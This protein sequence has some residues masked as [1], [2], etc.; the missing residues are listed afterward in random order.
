MMKVEEAIN[1]IKEIKQLSKPFSGIIFLP[2]QGPVKVDFPADD[3]YQFLTKVFEEGGFQRGLPLKGQ[4]KASDVLNYIYEMSKLQSKQAIDAYYMNRYYEYIKEADK[5]ILKGLGY[6]A[7]YTLFETIPRAFSN[8]TLGISELISY[9]LKTVGVDEFSDIYNYAMARKAELKMLNN[10]GEQFMSDYLTHKGFGGAVAA[11]NDLASFMYGFGA[12]AGSLRKLG[13]VLATKMPEKFWGKVGRFL[14]T[15]EVA[16]APLWKKA[17]SESLTFT[18]FDQI[19]GLFSPYRYSISDIFKDL[20]IGGKPSGEQIFE[21]T[22]GFFTSLLWGAVP[23][24]SRAIDSGLLAIANKFPKSFIVATGARILRNPVS[25]AILYELKNTPAFLVAEV[26]SQGISQATAEILKTLG[27]SIGPIN[28][29]LWEGIYGVGLMQLFNMGMAGVL[30]HRLA[31][32]KKEILNELARLEEE[33]QKTIQKPAEVIDQIT[34]P[35]SKPAEETKVDLLKTEQDL[36]LQ[37]VDNLQKAREVVFAQ[38]LK[39]NA[40]LDIAQKYGLLE[41]VGIEPSKLDLPTAIFIAHKDLLRSLASIYQTLG[42]IYQKKP[43]LLKDKKIG[44]DLMEGL[45]RALNF[46]ASD[47]ERITGG[48]YRVLFEFGELKNGFKPI[49][50]IFVGKYKEGKVENAWLESF[51]GFNN[52]IKEIDGNY[53]AVLEDIKK[54]TDD[55]FKNY[56]KAGK[57]ILDLVYEQNVSNLYKSFMDVFFNPFQVFFTR[58]DLTVYKNKERFL[59]LFEK[60]RDKIKPEDLIIKF[61][62]LVRKYNKILLFSHFTEGLPTYWEVRPIYAV[63]NLNGEPY[64]LPFV[65]LVNQEGKTFA[66]EGL[67]LL[68]KTGYVKFVSGEGFVPSVWEGILGTELTR[69]KVKDVQD[70]MR[71]VFDLPNDIKNLLA[72]DTLAIFFNKFVNEKIKDKGFEPIDILK[73]I[74]ERKVDNEKFIEELRDKGLTDKETIKDIITTQAIAKLPQEPK[75]E[76][77]KPTPKKEEE[78]KVIQ[79]PPEIAEKTA[80]A[81]QVV[82]TQEETKIDPGVI[83]SFQA[84]LAALKENALRYSPIELVVAYQNLLLDV[85]SYGRKEELRDIIQAAVEELMNLRKNA[86]KSRDRNLVKLIDD[87]VYNFKSQRNAIDEISKKQG[88]A[89]IIKKVEEERARLET[90]YLIKYINQY[91]FNKDIPILLRKYRALGYLLERPDANPAEIAKIFNIDEKDVNELIKGKKGIK[92]R[93]SI[94]VIRSNLKD[95]I[96]SRRDKFVEA[97]A[98]FYS[99]LNEFDRKMKMIEVLRSW[100]LT[101]EEIEDLIR[102]FADEKLEVKLHSEHE[103]VKFLNS[104]IK[105]TVDFKEVIKPTGELEKRK[106][107][108]PTLE[109]WPS[110]EWIQSL[111]ELF[112]PREKKTIK[113][114][115]ASAVFSA[116]E[117]FLN[118]DDEAVRRNVYETLARILDNLDTKAGYEDLLKYLNEVVATRLNVEK[119]KEVVEELSKISDAEF[120]K[121]KEEGKIPEDWT[122]EDWIEEVKKEIIPVSPKEVMIYHITPYNRKELNEILIGAAKTKNKYKKEAKLQSI[123]ERGIFFKDLVEKTAVSGEAGPLTILSKHTATIDDVVSA[124]LLKL[125]RNVDWQRFGLEG[126]EF[127]RVVGEEEKPVLELIQSKD[128]P[129]IL[130]EKTTNYST[131]ARLVENMHEKYINVGLKPFFQ[132]FGTGFVDYLGVFKENPDNLKMLGVQLKNLKLDKIGEEMEEI[133]EMFL[134]LFSGFVLGFPQ[135]EGL[136]GKTFNSLVEDLRKIVFEANANPS[137]TEAR[138]VVAMMNRFK[139]NLGKFLVDNAEM[140]IKVSNSKRASDKVKLAKSLFEAFKIEALAKDM[141]TMKGLLNVLKAFIGAYSPTLALFLVPELWVLLKEIWDWEVEDAS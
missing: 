121:M 106:G 4:I 34:E 102:L 66:Q 82:Q 123:I 60:M 9:G 80:P 61:E 21:A 45:R 68:E 1:K 69:E 64:V 44:L 52:R 120:A 109:A 8:R 43:E 127:V 70:I 42:Y 115:I 54:F 32:F 79:K 67:K 136:S 18:A 91:N 58:K 37:A 138:M 36:Y 65:S 141:N 15:P 39:T 107:V 108:E 87:V 129:D 40:L 113:D 16:S 97:F 78:T 137:N 117:G 2:R 25:G 101:D 74:E 5:N 51:K 118:I 119:M 12:V 59:D 98:K 131:L 114:E 13:N 41:K 46:V 84:R 110:S 134:D 29:N 122:K 35:P 112:K 11:I 125:W 103:F 94:Y 62:N 63:L 17:I 38:T 92:T 47:I 139:D 31:K 26:G 10:I 22:A 71:K 130:V 75:P 73:M 88:A 100:G 89:E 111:T 20:I 49:K 124:I 128:M 85:A 133:Y 140:I 23:T 30:G 81:K 105:T 50:Y 104:P 33:I 56:T 7:Q 28:V 72:E 57:T 83:L 126:D 76:E 55:F 96:I 19:Q 53:E 27:Y 24:I 135:V 48:N 132:S 3:P 90:E 99:N 77:Q 93:D 86:R 14:I 95:E 6:V 116:V